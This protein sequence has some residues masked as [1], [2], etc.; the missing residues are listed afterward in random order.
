MEKG[1][2]IKSILVTNTTA[3]RP[4]MQKL[5]SEIQKEKSEQKERSREK[6]KDE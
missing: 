6:L 1:K 4:E 3:M 2:G 5:T